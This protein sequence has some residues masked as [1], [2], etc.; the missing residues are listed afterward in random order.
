MKSKTASFVLWLCG[1]LVV[2]ALGNGL[3]EIGKPALVWVGVAM[4]DIGTL[5]LTTLTDSIYVEVARGTYDRA[6]LSLYSFAL[7]AMTGAVLFFPILHVLRK[8]ATLQLKAEFKARKDQTS[9]P[10]TLTASEDAQVRADL[11]V[12]IMRLKNKIILGQ[13]IGATVAIIVATTLVVQN[14]RL[15]YIVRAA[16]HV[17][18]LQRVVAPYLSEA[19]R[20]RNSSTFASMRTRQQYVELTQELVAVAKA[21]GVQAPDFDIY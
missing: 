16:N 19:Q 21:N 5:G 17:E 14:F 11:Q 15:I 3:W 18:Q 4:L 6:S 12:G 13:R 2:G 7:G 1:A 8:S 10:G 20:L 9:P